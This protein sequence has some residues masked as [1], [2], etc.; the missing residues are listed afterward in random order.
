M[1]TM[2]APLQKEFEYYIANQGDLV[3]VHGFG[4]YVVIKGEKVIGVYDDQIQAIKETS[5]THTPGTFLVQHC[6]PGSDSYTETFHSRVLF[7]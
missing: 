6:V 1:E 3:A 7:S 2:A 5:K 4:K